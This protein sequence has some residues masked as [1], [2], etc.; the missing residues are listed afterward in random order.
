MARQS[1][2]S[3]FS[4][5]VRLGMLDGQPHAEIISRQNQTDPSKMAQLNKEL[6]QAAARL[7]K[8]LADA[9]APNGK[10]GRNNGAL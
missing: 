6:E 2:E 10:G 4:V 9:Y 3:D 5:D 7:Q 8:A 1:K